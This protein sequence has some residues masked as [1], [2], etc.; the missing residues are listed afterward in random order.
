MSVKIAGLMTMEIDIRVHASD[1]YSPGPRLNTARGP[2][3]L[4]SSDVG[5]PR[6]RRLKVGA[7]ESANIVDAGQ[8][9]H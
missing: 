8:V 9:D 3:R 4:L 2:N 6:R 1:S 5:G 7:Q